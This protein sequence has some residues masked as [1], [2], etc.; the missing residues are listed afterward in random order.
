MFRYHGYHKTREGYVI[1]PVMTSV[2][3]LRTNLPLQEESTF[4]YLPFL[5]L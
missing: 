5:G 4:L 2:H 3:Y 1:P